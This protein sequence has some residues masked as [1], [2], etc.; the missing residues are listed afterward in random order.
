MGHKEWGE[1]FTNATVLL[2]G[3][4]SSFSTGGKRENMKDS[5]WHQD[6]LSRHEME[7]MEKLKHI[8]KYVSARGKD[9][10]EKENNSTG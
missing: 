3:C 1:E 4:K 5:S 8:R 2:S 10:T 6:S 7:T 9:R